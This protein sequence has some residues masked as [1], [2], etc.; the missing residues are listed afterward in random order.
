VCLRAAALGDAF[1]WVSLVALLGFGVAF[2]I[3]S[4]YALKKASL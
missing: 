4:M 1:P 2:F 3:G